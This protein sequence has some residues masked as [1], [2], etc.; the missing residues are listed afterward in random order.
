MKAPEIIFWDILRDQGKEYFRI[1]RLGDHYEVY[2]TWGKI[3]RSCSRSDLEET[4]KVGMSLYGKVLK[5][6]GV[7]LTKIAIE[8]LCMMFEPERVK[9]RIKDLH[10][11]YGFKKIDHWML[12]EG[13]EVYVLTIDKSYNEYYLVDKVYDHSKAKLQAMLK[14]KLVCPKNS[15]MARIIMSWN[16]RIGVGNIQSSRKEGSSGLKDKL[17]TC[18]VTN[19]PMSD[20]LIKSEFQRFCEEVRG[21]MN[22]HNFQRIDGS[23]TSALGSENNKLRAEVST[24]KTKLLDSTNGIQGLEQELFQHKA[25][26]S[27]VIAALKAQIA[28]LQT[29]SSSFANVQRELKDIRDESSTLDSSTLTLTTLNF[30]ALSEVVEES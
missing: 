25:V 2:A 12:Y 8:Y 17:A 27:L 5:E 15:E 10:H 19:V 6:V 22:E 23:E 3:I 24:L 20:L 4:H 16:E 28:T 11:E 14:A 13:C 1:N 26:S 21:S 18:V 29:Q 9:N 7:S 30:E